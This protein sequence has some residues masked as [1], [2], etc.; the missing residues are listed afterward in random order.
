M[1]GLLLSALPAHAG[2]SEAD[3]VFAIS[4]REVGWAVRF[5]A[6][7]YTLAHEQLRPSSMATRA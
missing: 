3:G 1:L 6:Q 2:L 7:G 5:A 4:A